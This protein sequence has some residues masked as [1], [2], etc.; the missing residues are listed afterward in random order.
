[1]SNDVE[2]LFFIM[3]WI[4]KIENKPELRIVVSFNPILEILIFTGQYKYKSE[5]HDFS[6]EKF[7]IFPI[8]VVNSSDGILSYKPTEIELAKIKELLFDTYEKL[9][10]RVEAHKNI[11]ESF[12]FITLIEVNI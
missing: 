2:Y 9:N 4:I 12:K 6:V 1:M 3:R 10:N 7:P 11:D 5:W 8:E